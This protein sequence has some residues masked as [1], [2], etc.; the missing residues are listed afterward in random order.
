MAEFRLRVGELS[1]RLVRRIQ[2]K[3][4]LSEANAA[5]LQAEFT[6]VFKR[7][8]VGVQDASEATGEAQVFR[9]L[10]KHLHAQEVTTLKE[11]LPHNLRPLPG[12]Q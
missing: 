12:E 1:A 5:A 9:V 2:A 10:Q 3:V 8:F 7:R 4:A 11:T 6:D